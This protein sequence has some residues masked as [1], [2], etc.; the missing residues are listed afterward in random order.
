MFFFN[1]WNDISMQNRRLI[2]IFAG[3]I[4]VILAGTGQ[5]NELI[6]ILGGNKC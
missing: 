5:L 1:K 4:G 6:G 2:I 3:C